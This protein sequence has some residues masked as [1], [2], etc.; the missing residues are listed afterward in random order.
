MQ[1]NY[2]TSADIDHEVHCV[3]TIQIYISMSISKRHDTKNEHNHM[4][5]I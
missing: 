5:H 3:T 4:T 1:H 2:Y